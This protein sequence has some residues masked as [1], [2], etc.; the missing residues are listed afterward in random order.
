M[1]LSEALR[2]IAA[3]K[4]A[5]KAAEPP[6]SAGAPAPAERGAHSLTVVRTFEQLAERSKPTQGLRETM[7]G[8]FAALKKRDGDLRWL[9]NNPFWLAAPLAGW[10]KVPS[11]RSEG[12]AS[13]ASLDHL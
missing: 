5:E 2:T 3:E 7:G 8:A 4:A 6:G 11:A 1:R 12:P 13:S 9:C 10:W